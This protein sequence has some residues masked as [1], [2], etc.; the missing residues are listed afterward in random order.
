MLGSFK[1]YFLTL[2]KENDANL[3][4][5]AGVHGPDAWPKQWLAF[6]NDV[7]L[8]DLG[9]DQVQFKSKDSTIYTI[10]DFEKIINNNTSSRPF[11]I[12]ISPGG[13]CKLRSPFNIRLATWSS[14]YTESPGINSKTNQ[15]DANTMRILAIYKLLLNTK[16]KIEQKERAAAGIEYEEGQV[17]AINDAIKQLNPEI[18]Y[19]NLI[20]SDNTQTGIRFDEAVMIAGNPKADFA[21]SY[22]GQEVYWISYKEGDYFKHDETTGE[23]VVS[24]KVPF[25]QYGEFKRLYK[26]EQKKDPK[27]I[28]P[29]SI[30]RFCTN[31]VK[32]NVGPTLNVSGDKLREFL[33]ANDD[34]LWEFTGIRSIVGHWK[35]R[36]VQESNVTKFH[37]IPSSTYVVHNFYDSNPAGPLS[38][39]AL[40]GIY[41]ND[42]EPGSDFGINNVNILLQSTVDQITL[43]EVLQ[44]DEH[45]GYK[46]DPGPRGHILKNPNLPDA[47]EYIP[48]LFMR[49]SSEDYFAFL[50]VETGKKEV[51]LGGRSFIYP[52][53]KVPRNAININI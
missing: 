28:I 13:V 11:S 2:L 49:H 44:Y 31:I 35:S 30:N 40:K 14:S 39:F 3:M 38:I 20:N 8:D 48:V 47:D 26:G 33:K 34:K 43:K 12:T 21:L 51:L 6:V 32:E 42:Y 7:G 27:N 37:L 29:E 10:A 17:L 46:I 36:K 45:L 4:Q 25:Q 24:Q 22:K 23:M 16:G 50:N 41:G 19:L 15:L 18:G 5:M 52:K 1:T 53:G 9:L